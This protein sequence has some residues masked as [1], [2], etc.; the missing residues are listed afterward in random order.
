MRSH[1][2]RLWRR[3]LPSFARR[4]TALYPVP[5]TAKRTPTMAIGITASNGTGMLINGA[6][7]KK[8]RP[9]S[10]VE[11]EPDHTSRA[12]LDDDVLSRGATA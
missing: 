7:G 10:S 6:S 12:N 4:D 5:V 9:S 8:E 3:G 2:S 1:S 11:A